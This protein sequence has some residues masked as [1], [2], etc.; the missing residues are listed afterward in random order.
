M[1]CAKSFSLEVREPGLCL[2]TM[3]Y[4]CSALRRDQ[5]REN[6]DEQIPN[7]KQIKFS[8]ATVRQESR[9]KGR[10]V[11]VKKE[12]ALWLTVQ[13]DRATGGRTQELG[14]HRSTVLASDLNTPFTAS[15]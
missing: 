3:A 11:T 6:L 12:Q 2:E 5:W 1:S 13:A 9:N 10:T 15:F 7:S 14:Q 8:L 4:A